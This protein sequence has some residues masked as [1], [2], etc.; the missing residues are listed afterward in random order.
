MSAYP[1]EVLNFAL[2]LLGGRLRLEGAEVAALAGL[3]VFCE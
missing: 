1:L 2:V 3:G